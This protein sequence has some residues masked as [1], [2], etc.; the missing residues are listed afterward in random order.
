MAMGIDKDAMIKTARKGQALPLCTDHGKAY[1]PGYEEQNTC[2]KY[3]PAGAKALLDQNGWTV[4]SDGY[5]SK[6]GQ[7]LEFKYTT[8]SGKP[9]RE[10]DETIIQANLKDI[11]IKINIENHPADEFFG[12]FMNQGKHQLAE[13][14]NA[15]VYDP[16]DYSLLGC[17]AIPK[18][19]KSG[20][21]WSFWCNQQAEQLFKQEQQ[22]ADPKVRQDAF[23]KLHKLY[24]EE[25][26][27]IV[28]YSP[29][30]IAVVK[31]T[32]HNY[33][34]GPMGASETINVWEWWC[35]GG[36]C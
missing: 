6:G 5:R 8:T 19:G 32:A 33:T 18:N 12:T 23:T 7:K 13:F 16:D 25:N 30:D 22:S 11:G 27:I 17:N 31:N 15:W 26:P 36:Q 28:L 9:W 20:S 24:L 34:P 2:P 35:S 1:N 4:G 14:E 29:A 3:D 10:D 21:N